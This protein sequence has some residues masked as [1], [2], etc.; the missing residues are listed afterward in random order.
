MLKA[1]TYLVRW[2]EASGEDSDNEVDLER[3]VLVGP[4]LLKLLLL[5]PG[6]LEICDH[7]LHLHHKSQ[8][9]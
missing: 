9:G 3:L 1:L 8:L 4:P 6:K 5:V 2:P 7:A